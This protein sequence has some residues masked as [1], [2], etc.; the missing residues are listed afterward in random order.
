MI[1][2]IER[3]VARLNN[4]PCVVCAKDTL[5]RGLRCL[6]CGTDF[7]NA[8]PSVPFRY[9]IRSNRPPSGAPVSSPVRH[10]DGRREAAAELWMGKRLGCME[11]LMGTTDIPVRRAALRGA[12]LAQ[13][14]RHAV[15]GR[16]RGENETWEA[17]W[18]RIFREPL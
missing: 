2:I 4:A 10:L 14:L 5:H 3:P 12:I 7:A 16:H 8:R 1:G 17:L 15:A 9:A 18:A 13:D 11:S 6:A